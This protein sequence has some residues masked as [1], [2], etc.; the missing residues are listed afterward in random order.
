VSG[1]SVPAW[2]CPVLFLAALKVAAGLVSFALG[3][4]PPPIVAD[5]PP[6]G[7]N[8][9][10]ITVFSATGLFLIFGG[11]RDRRASYLGALYFLIASAF[12][13]QPM[14]GISG[15]LPGR[16]G[17]LV[18]TVVGAQVEAFVP[19]LVWLFARD[20]PEAPSGA[21]LRQVI[22]LGIG[23]SLV[24][25]AIL[26]A[27]NVALALEPLTGG[28]APEILGYA[29]RNGRLFHSSLLL[30]A[31]LGLPSII[32]KARVARPI[33]RRRVGLFAGALALGL[34]PVSLAL[35]AEVFFPAYRSTV[36]D[37]SIQ[38]FYDAVIYFLLL[39]VPVTTSYSVI[40]DHVL[41]VKLV[42][43]TAL[44]YAL[45]RYGVIVLTSVPFAGLILYFYRHRTHTVGTLF[46]GPRPL[47]MLALGVL[48]L[49][50][51]K[52]RRRL[53]DAVDRRF[54]RERVD[55]RRT[56]VALAE[57]TRRATTIPEL[58]A[59]LSREIDRALHVET[60]AVFVRKPMSQEFVAPDGSRR[61]L[62]TSWTLALLI[63]GSPE[64]LD[65]D[66]NHPRSPF[67]RLPEDEREWLADAACRLLVPMLDREGMLI[68]LIT[69]GEKKSE[70]PFDQDDRELLAA[71]SAAGAVALDNLLLR[72]PT[73]RSEF[74]TAAIPGTLASADRSEVSL[75]GDELA[76]E[77]SRC[78]RFQAPDADLCAFCA[79]PLVPATVPY[80][81]AGKFRLDALIGSGG[82]GVVYLATDLALDRPVAIKTL[83]RVSPDY[84]MRL[85]RE[86]RV[87]ALVSH[88]NLATIFGIETWRGIPMLIF[89]FVQAGTLADRLAEGSRPPAEV[90]RMGITLGDVLTRAHAAGIV[91]G[92]IKPS[93]IGFQHDGGIKL[94]D[95][96]VARFLRDPAVLISR[97]SF[98][99]ANAETRPI[100]EI[101]KP[102]ADTT[103]LFGTLAYLSP[104][105]LAG[106]PPNPLFDLWSLALVM[107]ESLAGRNPMATSNGLDTIRLITAAQLPDIRQEASACPPAL[108]EFLMRAL[109]RN[110]AARPASAMEFRDLLE[111]IAGE[112][113]LVGHP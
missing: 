113:P 16:A 3:L 44:Q 74:P 89:E 24:S 25:G 40:V 107:Y 48:G 2:L 80:T 58:A 108:G 62:R 23:I 34:G 47:A 84:A 33:E 55:A 67:G 31:F 59:V 70:L 110:P 106:D 54:F 87:A 43:R 35:L 20:F 32:A 39:S 90:V 18:D 81:L 22:R 30:V 53:L 52:M 50:G 15:A 93:N 5:A 85:R 57:T 91:H 101:A 69:L 14:D 41:D 76:A 60:V 92:D 27:I 99:R 94:L 78:R 63:S 45:T 95:F 98:V 37:P 79:G 104:E 102:A 26:F 72:A 111:Q 28:F 61:P 112:R 49:L 103:R 97:D 7:W 100:E 86:A 73:P 13:D 42:V 88:P 56:L 21:R 4:V 65:V 109:A 83:P 71:V 17:A 10:T 96:G 38:P 9:L 82:M 46:A 36:T 51:L 11:R 64:A 105:A 29:D 1:V 75:A 19:L 6:P 66:L 8:L 12:A 77:C 68:G